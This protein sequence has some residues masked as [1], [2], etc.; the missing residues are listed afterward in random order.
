MGG[1]ITRPRG[2]KINMGFFRGVLAVVEAIGT[3]TWVGA[4]VGFGAA[5]APVAARTIE[6]RDTI[7]KLTGGTLHRIARIAYAGGGTA[8]LC[9]LLRSALDSRARPNDL[10]RALA[11]ATGV[12]LIAYHDTT[13]IREMEALQAEMGGS[14]AGIPEDDPRRVAYRAY[15]KRSEAIFGGALLAGVT[16]LAL[17]SLR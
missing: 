6:D 4:G 15:H 5:S 13:I 2:Q 8:A 3:A 10:V 11:G 1:T 7:A 17:A 12:G 16:Q 9:A 14:L